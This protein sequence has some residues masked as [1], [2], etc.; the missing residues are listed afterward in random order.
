[1]IR[2]WEDDKRSGRENL[3]QA[4]AFFKQALACGRQH[5]LSPQKELNQPPVQIPRIFRTNRLMLV[6]QMRAPARRARMVDIHSHVLPRIEGGAPSFEESLAMLQ[7]AADAGTTDIVAAP[8]AENADTYTNDQ[9]QRVFQEFAD[10]A[11]GLINLHFGCDFHLTFEN[12]ADAIKN[13]G[14]YT[15]NKQRYLMVELPGTV[16]F[17]ATREALRQLLAAR[18]TPVIAHPERNTDLQSNLDELKGWVQD[19]CLLQLTGYSFLGHF[20]SAAKRTADR[21]MKSGLVH[22]VASDAHDKV[23]RSPDLIPAFKYVTNR[24]GQERARA[25][26]DA[27]PA[28]ALRGDPLPPSK[29]RPSYSILFLSH[30]VE[31][32]PIS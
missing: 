11:R 30:V 6:W 9:V 18:I 21:L 3:K 19:G 28:A 17:H 24:F 13:P 25:L 1:M 12:V 14:K 2:A 31:R 4:I 32:S 16:V 7:I 23:R 27:N 8:H 26:F 5:E 29:P 15:L 20:G 22:F 10:R